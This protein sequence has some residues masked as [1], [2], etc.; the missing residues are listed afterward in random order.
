M[1]QRLFGALQ[2]SHS[3]LRLDRFRPKGGVSDLDTLINYFWNIALA[4]A[5]LCPVGSVEVMLRTTIHDTLSTHFGTT[6]W[7]DQH[8]LL[9]SKQQAKV[10]SAKAYIARRSRT[11][12]RHGS[13]PTGPLASG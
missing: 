9:E 4:E 11:V 12:T 10:A 7:Y 13:S 1:E 8:G 6:I 3:A 2:S 5:L